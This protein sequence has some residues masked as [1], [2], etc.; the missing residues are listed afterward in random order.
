MKKFNYR[1]SIIMD[2]EEC[3]DLIKRANLN[4]EQIKV[5]A[6]EM[7]KEKGTYMLKVKSEIRTNEDGETY[8]HNEVW[9]ITEMTNLSFGDK[10]KI[11]ETVD[12][13]IQS[14]FNFKY[15]G[16]LKISKEHNVAKERYHAWLRNSRIFTFTGWILAIMILLFTIIK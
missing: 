14:W 5:L 11:L 9:D 1:P 4:D 3:Q 10:K 2:W 16:F 12:K 15:C 8:F 6:E 7:Y 13:Y